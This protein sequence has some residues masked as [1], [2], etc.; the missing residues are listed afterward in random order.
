MK[1]SSRK[2]NVKS[3]V[4]GIIILIAV[5]AVIVGLNKN[6]RQEVSTGEAI[7]IGFLGPLTGDAASIGTNAQK[8][9]ELAVK[10]INEAGGINGRKIEVTY[11]DGKCNAKDA[12]TAGNKLINLDKVT[13]IVG[14]LCSSETMAIA[15]VAEQQKVIVFSYCSSAPTIT[16]A[17][18]YI[19]RDYASDAYE[20]FYAAGIAKEKLNAKNVAIL[21]C[22]S[23]WCVG[24][25]D[26]FK[27]TFT[28]AGGSVV[29]EEGYEQSTNDLKTQLT[30]VKQ[31][32][33]DM[34]YFVGYTEASII[35]INQMKELGVDVPTLGANAWDDAKIW[36]ETGAAGEGKMWA[37]INTPLTNAFK[38]KMRSVSVGEVTLCTPQA[39]D[40]TRI[41][42]DI[43]KR[44]GTDTTKIKDELYKVKDY[45]GVS[46]VITLDNNGD[47][48]SAS[49]FVTKVAKS[50]KGEILYK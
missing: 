48:A 19:F 32:N 29:I 40:A 46:G 5:I 30:K 1:I 45:Q 22:L 35:G 17:G 16:T 43:M 9:V 8:G 10:E 28:D 50:G 3:W 13:A 24:I 4:I 11:E 38:E 39:Y 37:V 18:D 33:P 27:K 6:A 41:L 20:G 25:K 47:L 14:G 26:V 23:D 12:A 42:A 15:P 34:L 2:G 31:A 7:K 49:G 21:Y 44:V 36:A